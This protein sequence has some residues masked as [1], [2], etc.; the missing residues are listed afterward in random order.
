MKKRNRIELLLEIKET[1]E[2]AELHKW[3]DPIYEKCYNFFK[4]YERKDMEKPKLIVS[5]KI[6]IP[7][8]LYNVS[9]KGLSYVIKDPKIYLPT[10]MVRDAKNGMFYLDNFCS[11]RIFTY[12][13]KSKLEKTLF[14]ELSHCA[15]FFKNEYL[16]EAVA[17][18]KSLIVARKFP[19]TK[20]FAVTRLLTL[21]IYTNALGYTKIKDIR[22]TKL[23]EIFQL[24]EMEK[25]LVQGE[26]NYFWENKKVVKK[27]IKKQIGFL[28]KMGVD[29]YKPLKAFAKLLKTL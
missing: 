27:H 18:F 19:E 14:H 2:E 25:N 6:E 12:P 7:C 15:E 5:N 17:E 4:E 20:F 11:G 24:S 1:E 29:T 22:K 26:I 21:L 13:A 3:V 23:I 8:S 10:K 16:D 9:V 28:K